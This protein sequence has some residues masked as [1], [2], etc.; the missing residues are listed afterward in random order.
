VRLTVVF[1]AN[2]WTPGVPCDDDCCARA[3][4]PPSA[5]T[6]KRASR[7]ALETE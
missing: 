3:A 1:F 5:M 4:P 2:P 6:A 7:F